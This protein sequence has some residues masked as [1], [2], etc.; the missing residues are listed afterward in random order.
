MGKVINVDFKNKRVQSKFEYQNEA[1]SRLKDDLNICIKRV[2]NIT[3]DHEYSKT[4]TYQFIDI[5][6]YLEQKY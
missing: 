4:I 2:Y 3:K 5:I 6:Q 1:I